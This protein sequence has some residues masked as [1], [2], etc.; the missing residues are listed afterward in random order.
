[1]SYK[2]PFQRVLYFYL[3]RLGVVVSTFSLIFSIKM[4]GWQKGGNIVK[5]RGCL[6]FFFF[7]FFL[8]FGISRLY[9]FKIGAEIAIL[10]FAKA[11][12][13]TFARGFTPGSPYMTLLVSFLP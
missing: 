11:P 10:D 8:M 13:P 12:N 4:E 3:R 1:M 7:F 6:V 9:R 5:K 2:T